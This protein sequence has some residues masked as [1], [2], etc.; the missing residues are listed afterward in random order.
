[1]IARGDVPSGAAGAAVGPAGTGGEIRPRFADVP[2]ELR[3]RLTVHVLDPRDGGS[4]IRG[5]SRLCQEQAFD[6]L[7]LGVGRGAGRIGKGGAL[8]S[9]TGGRGAFSPAAAARQPPP[10]PQM[11]APRGEFIRP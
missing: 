4:D 8:Y 2:A 10:L 7:V 11:R 1:M 5:R 6:A 3:Q 9:G